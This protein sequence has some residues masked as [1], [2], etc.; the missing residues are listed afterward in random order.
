MTLIDWDASDELDEHLDRE[1]TPPEPFQIDDDGKADWACRKIQHYQTTI[2]NHKKLAELRKRQIDEWLHET[3]RDAQQEII[4]FNELLR[5]YLTERLEHERT[6]TLKLPSGSISLN[7]GR[8]EL[9]VGSDKAS[10][11][12]PE[13]LEYVRRHA[14]DFIKIKESVAWAEF[15]KTLIPTESGRVVTKDGEILEFMSAWQLPEN[16]TVKGS[17]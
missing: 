10:A 12:S 14:V 6:K 13:L 4:R 15:K 3:T 9:F 17:K 11:D 1:N 16:I 5:P 8:T 7:K 2:D